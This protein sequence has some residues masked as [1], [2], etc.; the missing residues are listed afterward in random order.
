MHAGAFRNGVRFRRP[1][2]FS[3][4]HD[5]GAH[6][7]GSDGECLDISIVSDITDQV[8][9]EILTN[10]SPKSKQLKNQLEQRMFSGGIK[11]P[12]CGRDHW[13]EQWPS[14]CFFKI[15]GGRT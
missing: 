14:I 12:T 6:R 15:A 11:W 5:T 1:M 13:G 10:C 8:A 7:F 3:L 4:V 9:E 2:G